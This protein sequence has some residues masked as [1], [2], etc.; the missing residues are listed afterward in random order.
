MS[1][2]DIKSIAVIGD[3][4]MTGGLA[5]EGLNNLGADQQSDVLVILNDNHMSI[6]HAT[7]AL[8]KYLLR[9][10]TSRRYNALKQYLW[11]LLAHTPRVL[12]LCRNIG[13]LVKRGVLNKSNLFESLNM[14][15]F[16]PIDG[17]DLPKMIRVLSAL[18]GISGPKLLHV[19]TTKGKG[20]SQQRT[21]Q[22]GTPR[23]VTTFA[24]GEIISGAKSD[25]F[26]DVF[27]Q[28]LVELAQM[29]SRVVG[30]TPAMISGCSM[31]LL[32]EKMPERC[33]D[34]GI[35]EGHAV[36]FAAGIAASGLRPFCNVY[37]SFMQRAYDNIIHDVAI[38]NLPVTLCLD[39][40]GL[41]GED[42][43]THHG[44]YDLA[45]LSAVPQ[46]V[47][48]APRNEPELRN[49]MFTAL[50]SQCPFAIRYPRGGSEGAQGA[51]CL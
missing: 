26:Q 50:Q 15:Y 46:L 5:F 25:R 28:T 35:A 3:G 42:G 49:M 48:A 33:F 44:A 1:G 24:T 17:H 22:N 39:R 18:K 2:K 9:I 43:S 23:G 37:S 14:R 45:Y 4:S 11:Q 27:G 32:Q 36:T 47:V 31:N 6:D 30:I 51:T 21:T 29:D 16:G 13:R 10:S 8:S 19:M 41:V 12:G 38:Q 7:G 40:A 34:V 20:T